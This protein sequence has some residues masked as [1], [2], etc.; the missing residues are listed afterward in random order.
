MDS[1]KSHLK[2]KLDLNSEFKKALDGMENTSQNIFITGKAGTGKSTLLNYFRHHTQKKAVV[3]APTGVAALNVQGQTIHSFFRFK[4]DITLD[5]IK[6]ISSRGKNIYKK[7]E[8]IIID[9][10][11]MVRA[12]ILDCVDRFMRLN[13][14]NSSRPF[15][16]VQMIFFGD[17][18]QLPPV[19][20]S[21]EREIFERHYVS[22]YFFDSHVFKNFQ[23]NWIELE[24][25]YRQSDSRF[26]EI[27]NAIRNN[28]PTEEHLRVINQRCKPDFEPDGKDFFIQLTT[29][30]ALAEEINV[31]QLMKLP[32]K[33][34]TYS[35]LKEGDFKDSYLPTKMELGL[36]VGAQVMMLN[37]DSSG[38]WVNGSVGQ[39]QEI[40]SSEGEDVVWVKLTN[41]NRVEVTPFTW[42]LYQF[43]FDEKSQKLTSQMVGSFTQYPMMLAWAVT[44]HKSQGRTFERL[45]ID[46]GKGTFAHGQMYVAL[47]RSTSLEGIFLKK[48]VQKRHIF[49][50]WRVVSFVTRYQYQLSE[51]NIPMDQKM[52]FIREAIQTKK[53]L[54]VIYLKTNDEKSKRLIQ[55]FFAGELNYQGKSFLGVQAYD[56][57]RQEERTFRVDRILEIKAVG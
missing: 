43:S 51:K 25:I 26:I 16:G 19:V 30:N 55:P 18:Y 42:E 10:I 3:L 36:K 41:G 1:T 48:P 23:M 46:I 17:L 8:S 24:K 44:I 20:P 15:G 28:T 37:N 35:G 9:E 27:L 47:S 4:P 54:E 33:L 31:S 39:I 53:S 57:Q 11:S 13:G 7:I 50:D 34:Y 12:D 40:D 32:G 38:R 6:K 14:Q 49:V 45:V 21:K 52:K 2:E 29:T 22:P 5:K 56:S